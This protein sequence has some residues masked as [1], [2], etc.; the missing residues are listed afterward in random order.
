MSRVYLHSDHHHNTLN[1]VM[2]LLMLPFICWGFYKNGIKL[3]LA[4]YISL[5][6][7]FKPILLVLISVL[8]T[9]V[10]SKINHEK[11]IGYLLVSNL[12]I[13]LIVMPNINLLGYLILMIILNF[14]YKKW[15]FNIVPIFMIIAIAIA[16]LIK[17]Y[18]FFNVL[19]NSV[20]HSYSL[21]DYLIGKGYG[22]ISNTC[23]VVSL[24]SLGVLS[25][26][27]MYK[28]QIPLMA[29]S[30]YYL[31]ALITIFV[32]GT[33]NQDLLLNNNVIFAF[34]FLS[35][36]SIYTPYSRGGR[37]IYGLLLGVLTFAFSFIDINLGVYLSLGIV[38]F[39]SPL[40]DRFIVGKTE[41]NLVEML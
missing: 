33:T 16:I 2:I 26:N 19:E 11:F 24:I 34:V 18:H 4:E 10:F 17:D 12:L 8:V 36:I 41:N 30:S 27:V 1:K 38:S 15:K 5:L 23:L 21:L 22:G 6:E 28:K 3:Y 20:E 31:F 39:L 9:W 25:F 13:S 32:T 7:M 14:F 29:F 40:I 37:Y 35:N